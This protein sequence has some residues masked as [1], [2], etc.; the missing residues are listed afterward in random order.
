MHD[1][2]DNALRRLEITSTDDPRGVTVALSGELDL[3]TTAELD[4]RLDRI[5]KANP[6]RVLLDLRGVGFMDSTGLASI[7]RAWSAASTNGHDIALRRGSPQVQ[8]LFELTGVLDQLT[9]ED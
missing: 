7:L 1:E 5:T 3:E 2:P 6:G 9:F 8:R 4:R